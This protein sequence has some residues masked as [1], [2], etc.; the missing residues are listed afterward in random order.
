MPTLWITGSGD[1]LLEEM[2]EMF[3]LAGGPDKELIIYENT[4]ARGADLLEEAE[5]A[6]GLEQRLI[7]FVAYAVEAAQ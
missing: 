3:D 5:F 6:A 7:D 1:T 2:L 4:L